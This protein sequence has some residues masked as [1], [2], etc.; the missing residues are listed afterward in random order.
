MAPSARYKMGQTQSLARGDG[1]LALAAYRELSSQEME[2][3]RMYEE[4][5]QSRPVLQDL[6]HNCPDS[7][8]HL[9][10][11]FSSLTS[12]FSAAVS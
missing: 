8:R 7:V 2:L 12:P 4:L 11:R 3:C 5:E 10:D 6:L 9:L 1:S